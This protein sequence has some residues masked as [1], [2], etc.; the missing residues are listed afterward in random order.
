MPRNEGTVTDF[1]KRTFNFPGSYNGRTV[2]RK[3]DD[4]RIARISL[5]TSNGRSIPTHDTYVSLKVE[6]VSITKGAIDEA[7]FVFDDHL[8]KERRADERIHVD[9]LRKGRTYMVL[10]HCGWD[11]YI[12]KPLTVEPIVEAVKN[13]IALFEG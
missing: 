4:D 6:I 10:G 2:T 7:V 3:I 9:G 1:L 8:D 5:S 11:W 12:A 13:Y